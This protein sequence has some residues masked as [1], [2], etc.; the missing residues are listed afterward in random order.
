MK[1]REREREREREVLKCRVG[2]MAVAIWGQKKKEDNGRWVHTPQLGR[3]LGG[4]Y[5]MIHV[6]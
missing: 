3:W 4:V 1:E 2:F 5:G 6:A